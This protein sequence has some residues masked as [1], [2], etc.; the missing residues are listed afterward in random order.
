[1]KVAVLSGGLGPERE[2]SLASGAA[3]VRA[4]REAGF[5]PVPVE[6][7]AGGDFAFGGRGLNPAAGGQ[8]LRRDGAAAAFVA[9]H[10]P[11]G[12]DGVIQGFL[13]V[14]RVPFTGPDVECAAIAMH[15]HAA[16]L[17]LADAGVPVAPGILLRRG[18]PLEAAG[19]APP[20]VAKPCRL[21]SSVGVRLVTR[22]DEVEPAVRAVWAMGQD[23]LLESYVPGVEFSC[24]V[25]DTSRGPEALPVVEIRP[26]AG[27]EFF[28][29]EAKYTPGQCEEIVR[30][31][32][33]PWLAEMQAL[34]VRCHALLG[35]RGF[36]RTDF[37]RGP[38]G[39]VVLEINAIPGLT[40]GSLLP[41]AAAAAGL[42]LGMLA[43][44][45]VEQALAESG[46]IQAGTEAR[47]PC[48]VRA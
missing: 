32:G 6:V 30:A 40:E 48:E 36:S 19:M 11:Y 22:A 16:R 26:C 4:L 44:D 20:L 17:L 5:E 24:P 43:R 47:R 38:A 3:V 12:E 42:T 25:R 15:K 7:T 21:G 46:G 33:E 2:V 1:M 14:L 34:A 39:P 31:G 37:I 28:D 29:Y 9:L 10:G 45:W 13:R 23:C 35:C 41:K 18:D 27:R 8:R